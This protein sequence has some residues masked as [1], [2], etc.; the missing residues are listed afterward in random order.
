MSRCGKS[1]GE[2]LGFTLV[3]LLVVITI[4]GILIAMLLPA[5]QA[6][7]GGPTAQCSNNLK[8]IGLALHSYHEAN[9]ILPHGANCYDTP[10]E[11]TSGTGGMWPAVILPYLDQMN[12]YKGINFSIPIWDPANIPAVQ[13]VIPTYICPS[14]G[15]AS[16]AL[17][18]GRKTRKIPA[19]PTST[20]RASRWACGMKARWAQPATAASPRTTPPVTFVPA[21]RRGAALC[22]GPSAGAAATTAAPPSGAPADGRLGGYGVGIFDRGAHPIRFADVTDGLSNTMMVGE[23]IPSQCIAWGAYNNN[24]PVSGTSIPLNTFSGGVDDWWLSC[25]F[26]SRHTGGANPVFCDGSVH[27]LNASI[28]YQLYNNL[29]SRAGNEPVSVP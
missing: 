20:I 26:K 5:V 1:R 9:D 28:D 15:V 17:S 10:N 7:R 25:G 8:Q 11:T 18:G 21:V 22:P 14:D 2:S 23:S 12:V 19:S 27:F 24:G 3:E 6:A 16:N 4:I 29:G 13:V